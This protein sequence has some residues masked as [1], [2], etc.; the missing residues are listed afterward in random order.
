[1]SLL[2]PRILGKVD[3]EGGNLPTKEVNLKETYTSA[4]L[5]QGTYTKN[6]DITFGVA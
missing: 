5:V 2:R 4:L 3:R 6:I 1:M